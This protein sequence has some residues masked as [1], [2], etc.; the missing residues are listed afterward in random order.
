MST[1]VDFIHPKF[2]D[3]EDEFSAYSYFSENLIDYGDKQILIMGRVNKGGENSL[4]I[5]GFL[6][7][8]HIGKT[9]NGEDI[10]QILPIPTAVRLD[11]GFFLRSDGGYGKDE[12]MYFLNNE[13]E[14]RNT[15]GMGNP[16]V[17]I[18]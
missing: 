17:I 2:G 15:S 13:V 6:K 8:Y 16:G 7:K 3:N 10:S 11:V 18:T 12:I 5:P 1:L 4:F 14:P 9:K